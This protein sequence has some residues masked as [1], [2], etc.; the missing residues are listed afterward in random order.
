MITIQLRATLGAVHQEM[1]LI[2]A[3]AGY[4]LGLSGVLRSVKYQ[5]SYQCAQDQS[6]TH[7]SS[8]RGHFCGN[9]A[10]RTDVRNAAIHSF[11][12]LMG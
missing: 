1:E 5:N 6:M 9:K 12:E 7:A 3:V 8:I 11:V 10:D 2:R 4:S